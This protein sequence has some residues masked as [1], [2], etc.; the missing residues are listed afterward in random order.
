[1]N[2]TQNPKANP[3]FQSIWDRAPNVQKRP[4]NQGGNT[5]NTTQNPRTNT[6]NDFDQYVYNS[7]INNGEILG[8][9][10]KSSDGFKARTVNIDGRDTLVVNFSVCVNYWNKYREAW[11]PNWVHVAAWGAHAE[12]CEKNLRTGRQVLIH[13]YNATHKKKIRAYNEDGSRM[14]INGQEI[15]VYTEVMKFVVTQIRFL[16]NVYS[17]AAAQEAKA[18]YNN[19]QTNQPAQQEPQQQPAFSNQGIVENQ[20]EQQGRVKQASYAPDVQPRRN[21]NWD[22]F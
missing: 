22:L 19:G 13:G 11:L 18:R 16:G 15:F 20:P 10:G 7:G 5:M 2:T 4:I 3:N 17:I 14:V 1:M 6:Y 12:E 21:P 8:N 9:V